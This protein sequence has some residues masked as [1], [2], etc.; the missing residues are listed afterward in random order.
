MSYKYAPSLSS[1]Y[2]DV[3]IVFWYTGTIHP[4]SVYHTVHLFETMTELELPDDRR[5]HVFG[6]EKCGHVLNT[7]DA[8]GLNLLK[9][10]FFLLAYMLKP[11]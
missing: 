3:V 2:F 5:V 1:I 8:S 7:A 4:F 9:T 6:Q 10:I 11:P